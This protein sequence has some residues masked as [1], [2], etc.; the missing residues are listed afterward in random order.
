[1][2]GIIKNKND[3]EKQWLISLIQEFTENLD[4]WIKRHSNEL[5]ALNETI[6]ELDI[7]NI[8]GK[9]TLDLAS[10]RLGNYIKIIDNNL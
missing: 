10:D 2:K 6:N 1:M 3:H 4:L 8:S 9:S 5:K 7:P